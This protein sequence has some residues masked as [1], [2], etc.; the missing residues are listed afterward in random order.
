[1]EKILVP[2]DGSQHAHEALNVAGALASA[3]QGKLVLLHCLLQNKEASEIQAMPLSC[4]LD[5]AVGE[6]LKSAL[7]Q[8]PRHLSAT[9]L[10]ADPE[11]PCQPAPTKVIEAIG[12]IVLNTAVGNAAQKGIPAEKL[13]LARG[14]PAEII[15]EAAE[16][17]HATK[18]VMGCRG[19]GD[20]EAFTIG[21]VSRE[22]SQ[23]SRCTVIT[24]HAANAGLTN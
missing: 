17:H 10:M 18:I 7:D 11:S 16:Q 20:L 5:P 24:V 1:M 8:P 15:I 2:T 9:E 4:K 12:E 6:S 14:I 23:K 21:S 22:V 19:L 13:P 3:N